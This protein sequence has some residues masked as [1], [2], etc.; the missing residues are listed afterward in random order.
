MFQARREDVEVN[1][2]KL[3]M[4]GGAHFTIDGSK[5]RIAFVRPNGASDAALRGAV[6]LGGALGGG[7]GIIEIGRLVG[8]I[9]EGREAGKQWKAY[10]SRR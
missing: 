3:Q 10:L 4:S 6:H 1:W 2:P 7:A 5:Y 8:S 9:K